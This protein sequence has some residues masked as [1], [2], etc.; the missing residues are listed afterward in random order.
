[1]RDL[2][3]VTGYRGAQVEAALRGRAPGTLTIQTVEN[4][5]FAE[6]ASLSLLAAR[7]TAKG[8][9]FLLV[10]A[11]HVFSA[12][13][14]RALTTAA[15][16][17]PHACFVAADAGGHSPGYI[18]EA[19]KLA[20]DAKGF[21]TAIGKG[22]PTWQALD[23]GA[24]ALTPAVWDAVATAP[25]DCELSAIF[26]ILARRRLLKAADITGSFWYDIDTEGDLAEASALLARGAGA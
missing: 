22:L 14:I 26:A 11:D 16:A 5:R 9:P 18:D 3:V 6:G 4:P 2:V 15:E 19:T 23:A 21:V 10:M 1:V 24:F 25:E 13:L 17:S 12:P 8:E 20:V 7:E